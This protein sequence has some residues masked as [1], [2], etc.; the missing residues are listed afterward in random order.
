MRI[1]AILLCLT[2]YYRASAQSYND[3]IYTHRQ[4]YKQEFLT[5][6]H[7]PLSAEDTGYLRFFEPNRIFQVL[8]KFTISKD[9]TPFEMHTHS[10]KIKMYR[11]YGSI[12]FK[13][14]NQGHSL[15]V[16]QSID[17]LKK[18]EQ[19]DYLFIPF[20]DLTN[21][22]TTFGGGRYIDVSIKDVQEGK[23]WIDFNKCYNP[24][25]AYASGYSCPIPPLANRLDT[26]VVAG[27]KLFGKPIKE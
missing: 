26:K 25:C 17:L 19:K 14:K 20:N 4:H 13:L 15:E 21:Y 16:Y 12:N 11:K 10:G 18:E 22:E 9:T 2:I 24:Y 1:L 3:S 5:D 23:I 6:S 7:S 27:E 8:A